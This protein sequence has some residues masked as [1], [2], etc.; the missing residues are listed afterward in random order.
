M[1]QNYLKIALR[2]LMRH[3]FFS[4]INI[5]GLAVGL[6]CCLL[7]GLYVQHELSYDR[8][9][10][11][12]DRIVRVTMEYS[13]QGTTEHVPITGTKVFPA[14]KR[15]FPEVENG[16]RFYAMPTVEIVY[17]EQ[18]F[19]EEGFV[20]ADST[21]F[22]VFSF[23]L[24]QGN[25]ETA[26]S[27]PDAI[28]LT[29]SMAKKYFKN[30]SPIGKVLRVENTRDYQVTGVMQDCPANSHIQF[31]FLV[32]FSNYPYAKTERWWGSN[33]YTYLLLK[34][35]ESITSLQ[36]KIPAYMDTQKEE[37]GL[38][39]NDYMTFFLE[40]LQR[41]HL[42]S[43]VAGGFQPGG[44]IR[45]VYI[46]SA[47][48]LL[49]L[50]IACGN[51]MNMTT[52]RASARAREVGI[53]KVVGAQ[54]RQLFWQFMGESVLVIGLALLLSLGLTHLAMP[55]FNELA[56][57][58]ILFKPLQN[59][60]LLLGS[61]SLVA[62]VSVMAGSYPALL[63]SGFQP[64]KILKGKLE[65]VTSG[66]TLR[67]SLIVLQFIISIGLI[68]CTLVIQRQLHFVQNK[69]LG[70]EKASRLVL[71][72]NR[73]NATTIQTLKNEFKNRP[74][75]E[76]V[77]VA[78]RT[79]T[80]VPSKYI[81]QLGTRE[82]IITANGVDQD[83]VKTM[84]LNLIAGTDFTETEAKE[85]AAETHNYLIIN[86][87]S[88]QEYGWTP[89]EAITKTVQFEGRP[90]QI[91]AVVADFHFASLH[92][93][94]TPMALFLQN[95]GRSLI[96][97]TTGENTSQVLSFLETKWQQFA[98]E[99]LFSYHF[100]DEE[101]D[102]LYRAEQ[103]T[104]TILTIFSALAICL[105]CLGLLGLS[106]FMASQRTKEIG[107]R[108]VLGASVSSIVALLSKDFLRLVFISA[109]LAFP[110]AWYAMSRWLADFTYRIQLEWW[111]FVG[112]GLLSLVITLLTVSFQAIRA[113]ISNPVESLRSE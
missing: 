3:R 90:A 8:L 100:L 2:N 113:A 76:A 105:A 96:V 29:E 89:Q 51:Y 62:L 11:K 13:V 102:Q 40:P 1:L 67:R 92:E 41:V 33:Y 69:K 12:A 75:I 112:A 43:T 55:Y 77:S 5:A 47:I 57:R 80:S 16:V 38:T 111:M 74:E 110:L 106:I 84:D 39:G 83:F 35:P 46:F 63:L 42:Y 86:A 7:L 9:H 97:K 45:Y 20:Y 79:L 58:E 48:A 27:Q 36:A 68:V 103:R 31:D 22:D 34:S 53:R 94:I 91:K 82:L 17:N 78:Y 14:F 108:K 21:I 30:E 15:I 95:G 6:T 18:R 32:P 66:L 65:T 81:L 50:A 25:P 56:G 93:P 73:L 24:S 107:I 23:K 28:V 101:F 109:L 71:P 99:Q 49:I 52:A 4:L 19:A 85:V 54:R 72:A 87:K 44:D 88:A 37:N 26:L 64:V 104:G 61:L 10:K 60:A 98:S 59:P 70:Y